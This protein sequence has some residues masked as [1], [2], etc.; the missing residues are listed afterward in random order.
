MCVPNHT[1]L[2]SAMKQPPQIEISNRD[3]AEDIIDA[4]NQALKSEGLQFIFA[5]GRDGVVVYKLVPAHK[6]QTNP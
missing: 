1:E 4:V 6:D 2:G 3:Q 5:G